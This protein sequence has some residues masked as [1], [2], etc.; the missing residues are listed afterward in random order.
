MRLWIGTST[1]KRII[2]RTTRTFIRGAFILLSTRSWS[3]QS[4]IR[5]HMICDVE[6]GAISS[7]NN[8][9]KNKCINRVY[10]K[11]ITIINIKIDN[12]QQLNIFKNKK[13]NVYLIV[14]DVSTPYVITSAESWAKRQTDILNAN[15]HHGSAFRPIVPLTFIT[16]VT[17][18]IMRLKLH[19]QLYRH[20]LR[21]S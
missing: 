18:A 3:L 12:T 8:R 1:F 10:I 15:V 19:T 21:L 9:Y 2:F 4:A 13:Y 6:W 17:F 20:K 5:H 16:L 14:Y 11:V 7:S